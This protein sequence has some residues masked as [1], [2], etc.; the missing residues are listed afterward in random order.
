MPFDALQIFNQALGLTRGSRTLHTTLPEALYTAFLD[1]LRDTVE[2]LYRSRV[3]EA[4]VCADD[5]WQANGAVPPTSVVSLF[6]D[7]CIESARSYYDFG[8][9]YVVRSPTSAAH[10]TWPTRFMR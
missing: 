10:P 3:Q 5:V 8:P 4:Y 6:E 7:G 1:R 2:A 9:A